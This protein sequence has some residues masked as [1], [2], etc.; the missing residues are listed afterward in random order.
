MSGNVRKI[1][2]VTGSRAEYGLLYWLLKE[3]QADP[4][5]QLQLIVTGMHL[6]PQFGLTVR[7]IEADGFVP[8]ARVEML[9]SSD[10]PV[11]IAKSMGLGVIG[12]AEALDRLRPDILVVLG[13]RF[14]IFA[15][16]Q[17]AMVAR[18]PI[19]HIHGGELTEGLID[20]AIRHSLTKMS[21]LHFV[22]TETYRKRV[23]QLG[24]SPRH[25]WNVGA[26]G[27]DAVRKMRLLDRDELSAATGFDLTAPYFV[28]T[29]HPVT[30]ADEQADRGARA[31]FTALE[32]FPNHNIV[33]T[34]AN[35]DTGNGA[36][37]REIESFSAAH[38]GRVFGCISLGQSRYL[39]ALAHADAVLG[40]SSS[41]L[42][43][44]QVLRVP[45][46]NVGDRQRGR[47]RAA[48]VIDVGDDEQAIIEGVARALTPDFRAECRDAECPFG[49]G[50][51]AEKIVKVL[52]EWPV[53]GLL[54]KQF[55]D[56]A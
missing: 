48:T 51:S 5:L 49:D 7:Q 41:G 17:A 34:G 31:L 27:V 10:T 55:Y 20:E 24:E 29:Y 32:R 12:F 11:G 4:R 9:L 13:D 3:I 40:N 45:T 42:I 15:A 44:A 21:H 1:C 33:V 36:V 43:E 38:P 2:V 37:S 46:V 19:A 52:G 54:I 23:I 18:I 56:M 47:V 28:V 16:A 35:A 39:S 53:E 25:V 22:A 8:D 6:S 50:H 30:L 14:E 26:A